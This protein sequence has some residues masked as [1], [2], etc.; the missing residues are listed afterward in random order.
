MLDFLLGRSVKIFFVSI[1]II[2]SGICV[3]DDNI[4]L[5]HIVIAVDTI[6]LMVTSNILGNRDR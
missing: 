3:R 2:G 6:L 5:A 4:S 1:S